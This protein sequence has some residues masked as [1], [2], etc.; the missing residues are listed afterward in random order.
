MIIAILIYIAT[1]IF[2]YHTAFWLFKRLMPRVD[3]FKSYGWAKK[4]MFILGFIIGYTEDLVFNIL[5][6]SPVHYI[7]NRLDGFSHNDSVFWPDFTDLN[8]KHTKKLTLTYRLQ[9]S[10]NFAPMDSRTYRLASV[11]SNKLNKYDPGH[12]KGVWRLHE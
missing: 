3:K 11:L 9:T 12:I 5:Y 4:G 2:I 7:L 10:I 6:G 1:G 8:W